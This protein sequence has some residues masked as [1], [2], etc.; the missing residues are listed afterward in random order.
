MTR[1]NYL[2]KRFTTKSKQEIQR[3]TQDASQIFALPNFFWQDHGSSKRELSQRRLDLVSENGSS[4]N[5]FHSRQPSSPQRTQNHYPI[6]Q[7]K[8]II[9]F[10]YI[11]QGYCSA[12]SKL[13]AR[14][15]DPRYSSRKRIHSELKPC[16]SEISED[17][18]PFPSHNAS[19]SD[20]RRSGVAVHL[21]KLKLGLCP[22]SLR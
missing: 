11:L 20:L 4:Y 21:S 2:F 10:T 6:R 9:S 7:P 5:L 14:L 13:P 19:V 16:H 15:L 8:C 22:G 18:S 3:L 17:T 1:L 12:S